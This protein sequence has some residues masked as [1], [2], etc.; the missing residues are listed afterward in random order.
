MGPP[1]RLLDDANMSSRLT[2]RNIKKR[3]TL[4]CRFFLDG[5]R[6]HN[7]RSQDKENNHEQNSGGDRLI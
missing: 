1:L 3:E 2:S 7:L 5:S 6:H 4:F